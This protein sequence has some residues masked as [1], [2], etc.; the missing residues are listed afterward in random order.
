MGSVA[1]YRSR[2]VVRPMVD[3]STWGRAGCLQ[4]S[5]YL[6][7]MLRMGATLRRGLER[8]TADCFGIEMLA[9]ERPTQDQGRR[10]LAGL[11]CRRWRQRRG[12]STASSAGIDRRRQG[13]DEREA[14]TPGQPGNAGLTRAWSAGC[15]CCSSM[16][17]SC[18]ASSSV[19]SSASPLGMSFRDNM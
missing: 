17:I 6:G 2:L 1:R 8:L 5:L 9:R 10:M 18:R 4:P 13:P 14:P 12:A 15:Y 7:A 16:M 19:G 3:R 11:C